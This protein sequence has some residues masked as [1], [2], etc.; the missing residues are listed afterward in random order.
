MK[1]MLE[2]RHKDF[3]DEENKIHKS[4]DKINFLES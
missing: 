4:I 3:I 2:N 1:N